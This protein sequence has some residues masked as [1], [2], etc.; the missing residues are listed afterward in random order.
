MDLAD[1]GV[2]VWDRGLMRSMPGAWLRDLID[3]LM[4]RPILGYSRLPNEDQKTERFVPIWPNRV[5]ERFMSQ[6]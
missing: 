4:C 3:G 1:I 2:N 6:R 5:Q